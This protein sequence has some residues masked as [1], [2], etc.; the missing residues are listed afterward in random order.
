MQVA[1]AAEDAHAKHPG[2]RWLLLGLILIRQFIIIHFAMR[3]IS[4]IYQNHFPSM[5]LLLTLSTVAGQLNTF[6]EFSRMLKPGGHLLALTPNIFHY[7]MIAARFTPHWFHRWW[8]RD[9]SAETFP[10]YYR[11]NSP[12]LLRRLCTGAGLTVQ[13]LELTEIYPYYLIRYW[14]PFLC[15]VLYE[16]IVNS[17]PL[18]KWMRQRMLLVAEKQP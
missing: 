4:A 16:R 1:A 7:S 13:Q 17:T 14:P 6:R 5:N 3:H 11:A 10:T 9:D 18:L 2:K 8:R 12:R 15:G